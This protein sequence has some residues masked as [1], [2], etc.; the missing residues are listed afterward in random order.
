MSNR[1]GVSNVV[2]N[3][4][5]GGLLTGKQRRDA[6]I[7][8][9]RFDDD[10]VFGSLL[11]P[12]RLRRRRS[13]AAHRRDSRPLAGEPGAQLDLPH[14]CRM[15]HPGSL[16]RGSPGTKSESIVRRPARPGN[17]ARLRQSVG[18]PRG[19]HQNTT[20]SRMPDQPPAPRRLGNYEILDKLGEGGMGEV[21]GARPAFAAHGSR[22]DPAC[23]RVQ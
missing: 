16:P 14:P 10:A 22:E 17:P 1:F 12:G 2:Y 9:T 18:S 13:T 11:A 7:A 23:R 3:P 19:P 8:G 20:A 6:P 21:A 15:H 5:A 4:L